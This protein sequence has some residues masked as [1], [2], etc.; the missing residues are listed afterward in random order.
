MVVSDQAN[1]VPLDIDVTVRAV[2]KRGE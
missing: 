1:G 2:W